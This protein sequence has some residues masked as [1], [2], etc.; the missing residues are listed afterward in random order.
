MGGE[1][2][3]G[4]LLGGGRHFECDCAGVLGE[5]KGA[6]FREDEVGLVSL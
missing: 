6:L 3:N 1:H 2:T 4:L 5:R